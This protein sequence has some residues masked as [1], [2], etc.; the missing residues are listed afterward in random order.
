M[1]GKRLFLA[2]ALAILLT[3]MGCTRYWCEH[4]GY[5]PTAAV[6]ATVL[7]AMLSTGG[8]GI[9]ARGAAGLLEPARRQLLVSAAALTFAR[10]V[11]S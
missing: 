9:R 3:S 1:M 4:Q 6:S 8:H 5:Y 10:R 11:R 2:A 7:C